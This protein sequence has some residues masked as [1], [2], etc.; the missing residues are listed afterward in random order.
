MNR[1]LLAGATGYLGGYIAAELQHSSCFCRAIVRNPAKLKNK[2][3][4]VDDI[5]AAELTEPATLQGCCQGMD[6]VISTVGITRQKDG[7]SYMD[8]DYQANLNLLAE[9]K[10]N[11]VKKFIYVSVL[12]GEKLRHL[13]ICAAKER[14]VAEL[15]KSGLDYCIVRPNGFF[16]DMAEFFRMAQQGRIYLFGSGELRANPI[17]GADLARCCVAAIN[18]SEEEIAIGGPE[19]LSQREIALRAFAVAGKPP[20][21]T[22]IPDWLRVAVLRLAKIFTPAK[23][24]GP[25]EFFLTVMAMDMLAPE[26]GSHRIKDF[27]ATLKNQ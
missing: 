19:T 4:S 13:Q 11:G 22:C 23:T 3:V 1:V 8:V 6:T 24:Y 18:G 21:I 2:G 5:F 17:H 16:S 14:F 15:R 10:K 20:K 12:N 26:Y 25:L 7:L 27:F 9:A